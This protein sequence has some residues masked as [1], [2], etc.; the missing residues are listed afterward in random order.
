[1]KGA[2][3]H[4]NE[5]TFEVKVVCD[6]GFGFLPSEHT[7]AIKKYAELAK[8][9][10][11]E[12]L[13]KEHNPRIMTLLQM[14]ADFNYANNPQYKERLDKMDIPQLMKEPALPS[15]VAKRIE[16][17]KDATETESAPKADKE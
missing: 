15:E 8:K 16:E 17:A 12:F 10:L 11:D 3:I 13:E 1:M 5:K 4:I 9:K 6:P 14:T 7:I 2:T